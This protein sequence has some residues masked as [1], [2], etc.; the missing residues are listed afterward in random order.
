MKEFELTVDLTNINDSMELDSCIE[1]ARLT[2]GPYRIL[3]EVYGEV[4]VYY[5]DEA[6]YSASD[7][8]D[9]L[10]KLFHDGSAYNHPDVSIVESNWFEV[11]YEEW[12]GSN[13]VDSGWSAVVDPEAKNP[14]ELESTLECWL[15]EYIED[16]WLDH[17]HTVLDREF[18]DVD[19]EVK[20][21]FCCE[22]WQNMLG[23]EENIKNFRTYCKE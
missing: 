20:D 21:D 6:F 22:L 19:G 5:K 14:A 17:A 8:P 9:E 3:L 4:E 13:W 16:M 11:F 12:I 10:L 7:M 1:V 23:D 2:K 15:D 18:P